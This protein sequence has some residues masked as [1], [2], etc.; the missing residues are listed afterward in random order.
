MER[1]FSP[2]SPIVVMAP[3]ALTG[4]WQTPHPITEHAIFKAQKA[5][6]DAIVAIGAAA[7]PK[8]AAI[9]VIN[10]LYG[11]G[12][13]PVLFKPTN[14][15]IVEFR[16]TKEQALS[17][18]I[19]GKEPEDRGFALTPFVKIRFD[20][21]G[22]II[23][24]D[25]ALAQGNYYFTKSNGEEIKVDYTFG[26]FEDKSGQLRINLHHSSLPYKPENGN[27]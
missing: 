12:Y 21:K 1:I 22:I 10:T 6:G 13:G 3:S 9:D 11:Y 15:A 18:F 8:E 24:R 5:W 26:Y 2:A 7:D 20:N 4:E 19:G 16:Y 14:A 27:A 23:H 17:Y 25:C